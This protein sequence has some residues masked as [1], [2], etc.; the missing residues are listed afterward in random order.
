[1][2]PR[3][4]SAIIR[5][6]VFIVLF[7]QSVSSS[8]QAQDIQRLQAAVQQYAER[9]GDHKAPAF[10][11]VFVDLDGDGRPDAVVLLAGPEW[12]GSGGCN[13]L[14]FRGMTDNFKFISGSTITNEPIRLSPTK[15]HGWRTL[16]VYSKGIG[17]VLMRFD[18]VRYPLNP[19]TQRRASNAQVNAAQVLIK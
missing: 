4:F 2:R 14:V 16:I 3:W 17:E 1:M 18:G 13:M 7:L 5:R 6:L 10:Q 12:C 19:S 9:K 11:H 8:V 15:A